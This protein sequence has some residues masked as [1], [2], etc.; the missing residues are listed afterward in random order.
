MN[1]G[2]SQQTGASDRDRL[3][4]TVIVTAIA[5]ESKGI[6]QGNAGNVSARYRDGFLITPSGLA[7][8]MISFSRA[9]TSGWSW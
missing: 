9:A 4:A 2:R 1:T 7:R 8:S 3:A 6:N 5:M